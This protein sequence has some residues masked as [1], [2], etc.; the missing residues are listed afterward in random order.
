MEL[1][2]SEQIFENSGIKFH[3]NPFIGSQVVPCGRTDRDEANSSVLQFCER[4]CELSD[5]SRHPGP[6]TTYLLTYSMVQS[7]S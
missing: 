5:D 3:E 6:D 7:P 4:S 1:E 2:V